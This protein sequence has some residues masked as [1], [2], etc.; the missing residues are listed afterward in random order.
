MPYYLL[1]DDIPDEPTDGPLLG[2]YEGASARIGPPRGAVPKASNS[3]LRNLGALLG[4]WKS[5]EEKRAAAAAG[6]IAEAL[7]EAGVSVVECTYDGGNDE[8]FAYLAQATLG[9]EVIAGGDL[10]RRLVNSHLADVEFDPY[11]FLHNNPEH[12]ALQEQRSPDERVAN[13]LEA[14][15]EVVACCLLGEGFGTGEFAMEGRFRVNLE[16][17]DVADLELDP[18]PDF[19]HTQAFDVEEFWRERG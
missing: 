15:S 5:P 17:G 10:A 13:W 3:V 7:K 1:M 6:L 18:P 11:G 4:L 12:L 2:S 8:G 16:T 14:F 19:R 9:N